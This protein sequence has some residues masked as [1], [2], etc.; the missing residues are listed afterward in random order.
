VEW[1]LCRFVSIPAIAPVTT[2]RQERAW[3][4]FSGCPLLGALQNFRQIGIT[5]T[6]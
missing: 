6:P 5:Q 1:R 2:V 4:W 3:Y